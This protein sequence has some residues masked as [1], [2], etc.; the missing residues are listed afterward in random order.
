MFANHYTSYMRIWYKIE[1]KPDCR[2]RHGE[3]ALS[4]D[5]SIEI[6]NWIIALVLDTDMNFIWKNVKFLT[7]EFSTEEAAM[8]FK[9]RWL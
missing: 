2:S 8:V 6:E 1:I 9:L 5:L 4:R 7:Y 3:P